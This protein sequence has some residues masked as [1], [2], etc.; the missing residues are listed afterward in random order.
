MNLK[1]PYTFI[2]IDDNSLDL[3]ITARLLQLAN[4]S[5][6]IHS[7][8]QSAEALEAFRHFKATDQPVI[9]LLDIQLPEMNG[10]DFLDQLTITPSV[11]VNSFRFFLLSSTLDEGDTIRVAQHPLA[12]ALISKPLDPEALRIQIDLL[13]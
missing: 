3:W 13:T 8:Q 7:F 2:L 4:L 5:S 9:V 10:F 6:T 1:E 12:I 11:D